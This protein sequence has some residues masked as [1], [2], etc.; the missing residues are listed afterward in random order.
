[1]LS[2]F[3]FFCTKSF[4]MRRASKQTDI[5]KRKEY[6]RDTQRC[7]SSNESN[8]TWRGLGNLFHQVP[9]VH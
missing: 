8:E 1:M 4:F 5:R 9:I 7:V 6:T 3:F 2:V